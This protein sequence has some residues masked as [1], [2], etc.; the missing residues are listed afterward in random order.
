M[1]RSSVSELPQLHLTLPRTLQ[2]RTVYSTAAAAG[3]GAANRPT[4]TP[5]RRSIMAA[6]QYV[7]VTV[8]AFCR[9]SLVDVDLF[10]FDQFY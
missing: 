7:N 9:S 2:C 6:E 8:T 3:A 4:S 5:L 10:R 1:S